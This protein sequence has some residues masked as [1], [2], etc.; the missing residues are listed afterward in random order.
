MQ[1]QSL[2]AVPSL[3]RQRLTTRMLHGPWQPQLDSQAYF[4]IPIAKTTHFSPLLRRES[5]PESIS[6]CRLSSTSAGRRQENGLAL[7]VRATRCTRMKRV[8]S[9]LL[10]PSSD[11]TA[12]T[13]ALMVA[14]LR[15]GRTP[16]SGATATS[17][18]ARVSGRLCPVA[19][20]QT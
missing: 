17:Y 19:V 5:R 4:R 14:L 15:T 13:L 20:S 16:E 8:W 12:R 9:L 7:M 11:P 6:Y 3:F 10:D 1:W 18:F 2:D